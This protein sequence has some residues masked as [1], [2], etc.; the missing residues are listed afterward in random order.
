MR[1]KEAYEILKASGLEIIKE[2]SNEAQNKDLTLAMTSGLAIDRPGASNG[3]LS[4]QLSFIDKKVLGEK[5][6]QSFIGSGKKNLIIGSKQL[7]TPLASDMLREA[8]V[9]IQ[10]VDS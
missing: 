4:Y 7:V 6:V 5:Q 8:G 3:Q 10:V 1:Y 9:K 2:T